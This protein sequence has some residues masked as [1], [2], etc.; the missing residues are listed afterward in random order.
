MVAPADAGSGEK[1][2]TDQSTTVAERSNTSKCGHIN[3]S[4]EILGAEGGQLR[5]QLPAGNYA[6]RW[7]DSARGE[8]MADRAEFAL[9]EPG[10]AALGIPSGKR[11]LVLRLTL[12]R[13]RT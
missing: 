6:A 1:A 8:Y 4:G 13:G 2:P 9:D 7:H 3:I 5:L 12:I 10:T 11:D